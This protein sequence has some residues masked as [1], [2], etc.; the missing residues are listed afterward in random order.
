MRTPA[1]ILTVAVGVALAAGPAPAL[2]ASWSA[3]RAATAAGTA[4]PPSV[5][6]DA[7]GRLAMGWV[8]TIGDRRRAEVRHG[9]LRG[10]L[11]SRAIVL[12]ATAHNLDAVSVAFTADGV[13][14]AV[15]RRYLDRAQRL[16][17]ATVSTG[18][19][20][21]GP[22]DLTPFGRESAYEPAF[23]T[24]PGGSLRITWTRRTTS[25]GEAVLGTAFGAPF[26]LPAP[27]IGSQPDV[28]VDPDGTT[29]VAWVQGGRVFAAQ[30]PAGG[31]FTA[32]AQ[33]SA[34]GV[35]RSPQLTVTD[36]GDVV[37]VWLSSAGQGNAVDV[38]VRPRAGA[39]GPASQ[40]VEPAQAAFEPRLASTSVGEVLL[41]FISTNSPNGFAGGRGVVRLQRLGRDER[42]VGGALT[43]S[44]AG[45]RASAPAIVHDGAAG[46]FVAWTDTG[47]GHNTVQVRRIVPGGILGP[48][49]TLARGAA[50]TTTP[51]LA[52][53]NGQA[54]AAW[55]GGGDV[56]YSVYR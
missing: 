56:R 41:A 40:V 30:A 27:G 10:R 21:S 31:A 48:V 35:T 8:R 3:P 47:S 53:V 13:L 32:P 6:V 44:P 51:V 16:R 45:V 24:G 2:A 4:S 37:A 5:A 17:G 38:A 50:G 54:V 22:F 42:P 49:R 36:D 19:S 7:R 25:A 18:G 12:D 14:A 11:R 20:T 28:A 33:I 1:A 52:G 29:V 23:V 39:F 55:L 43:L 15:W 9:T 46:A 26:T 34:G